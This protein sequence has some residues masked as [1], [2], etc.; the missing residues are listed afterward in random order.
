MQ[1]WKQFED[2]VQRILEANGYSIQRHSPR[3]DQGFDL[4]GQFNNEDWAIEVKYYRTPRAQLSLLESAA[5][6]LVTNG[7]SAN[8]RRG[9]L[10]ISSVLPVEFRQ[11]VEDKFGIVFVDRAD[12]AIW[13]SRFPKLS[14]ELHA[15]LESNGT[16]FS[17]RHPV[18]ND[19]TTRQTSLVRSSVSA[20]NNEGESLCAELQKVRVGRDGWAAYE[21]ICARI[22]KYL[23]PGDLHGW[24][25]QKRT[26]D[27]LNRFDFICRIRSANDFWRFLIEN[28]DSRYALFEFKNY[29]GKIKQGQVLTTEK[30]LLG[31]GLRRVAIIFSRKGA[32]KD[33]V[34]MTQGAMREHGKLMLVLDD[35]KVCQM[36]CMKDRGEDPSDVLFEIADDFL[37]TLPR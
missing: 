28:L 36:L 37:L 3:G 7:L 5:N 1:A 29:R 32:D 15:L 19:P 34:K 33:A 20:P 21:K 18:W 31:R 22:L 23:F 35:E 25:K 26:D 16:D 14:G 2:L 6:R 13:S 8:L 12:L 10:V 9:M 27:G 24:H 4:L 30:Y 11:A 17:A